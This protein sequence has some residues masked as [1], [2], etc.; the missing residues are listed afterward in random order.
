VGSDATLSQ[1]IQT[2]AGQHY[3]L[4]FWLANGSSGSNDFTVKWNGAS[5]LSLVNAP[6]QGYTQ[7]TYDIVATG[8][9][10]TLEFDAR[11]D[12]S[13]WSLDAISVAPVGTGSTAPP[14]GPTAP[15]AAPTIASLSPNTGVVGG[16]TTNDN[17]PTLTGT[18][19]ANSTVK[20]FDGTTQVGTATA[21]GTGQWTATTQAL[22]DATHNLT[23]T[24]TNA[25]GTSAPSTAFA[26]TVDTHAP[27][28]PTMAAYSQAGAAVGPTTTLNDLLLKGTAEAGSTIDVFDGGK[29]IGT[30]PTNTAGNWSYDTGQLANGSHSFTAKAID[31]A[32][33]VGSAS[34]AL[35][36]TVTA[37]TS[38]TSTA[39]IAFTGLHENLWTHTATIN[40]TADANSQIKLYDGNVL[41]GT[42]VASTSGTWSFKTGQLSNTVHVFTAQELDGTGHV[43]ATTSGEALLGSS[44]S[45]TLTSTTGNDIFVGNGHPDTFVF[46]ANFGHDVINDFVARGG[47]H[48]TIQFSKSEFDSFASVLSHA[49][50]VGQDVVISSGNDTLTLKNTKLGALNSHDFHFS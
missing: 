14:A 22:S 19:V 11:Q 12:P 23:A 2:T 39:S 31:A 20:V 7:Y 3:T 40:G 45:N 16:H 43:V 48:D 35:S 49:S 44:G 13:H 38:P 8:A 37:P 9:S 28:A 32:G 6:A 47:T 34:T 30:A 36:E 26:V 33:N 46:A 18:A 27:G 15:P 1:A 24:D 25:S 5:L 29:Q 50:Q 41:L 10:S 17:T 4:T 21:N 42:V